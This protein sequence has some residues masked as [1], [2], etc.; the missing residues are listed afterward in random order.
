[1]DQKKV[2]STLVSAL[3]T[4][5]LKTKLATDKGKLEYLDV[6]YGNKVFYR[7]SDMTFQNKGETGILDDHATPTQATSTIPH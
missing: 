4:D 6:R 3:D 5:P 7:F 2:W 1:M